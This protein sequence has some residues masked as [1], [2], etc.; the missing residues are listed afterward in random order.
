MELPA[1]WF[2]KFTVYAKKIP[3]MKDTDLL[4]AIMLFYNQKKNEIL[5]QVYSET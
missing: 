3:F 4:C 5:K 2:C 1:I